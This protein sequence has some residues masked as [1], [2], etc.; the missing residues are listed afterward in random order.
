[1]YFVAAKLAQPFLM[2]LGLACLALAAALLLSWRHPW[3]SRALVGLVLA[4]LVVLGTEAGSRRLLGPLERAYPVPP[5]SAAAPAAVVLSGTVDLARSTPERVELFDRAERIIEG[6]RLVRT[7]RARWLVISGGSGDPAYPDVA[8]ADFL[9]SLAVD[10]GVDRSQI[11]LQR[12]SRTTRE[13]AV[14]TADLLR[15]RG[16]GRFFLV[17]SGF[18]MPRAVGCFRKVGLDPIPYPVDLRTMPPR[19]GWLAYLPTAGGLQQSSLAFHEYVGRLAYW[20]LGY[21]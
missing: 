5:P 8:E 7:G 13:D 10:L 12:R 17:T 19:A 2:P 20:V 6:A 4:G 15:E 1:M 3:L 16:I 9:A 21:L 14:Y 11:L 18:H